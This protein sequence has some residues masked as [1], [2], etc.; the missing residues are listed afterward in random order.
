[1]KNTNIVN[2]G[3]VNKLFIICLAENVAESHSILYEIQ[4]NFQRCK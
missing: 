2:D 3:D 1:M 4:P